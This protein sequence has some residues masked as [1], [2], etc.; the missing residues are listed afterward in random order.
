MKT[1]IYRRVDD[2][3][4][5]LRWFHQ[6]KGKN[7]TCLWFFGETEEEVREAFARFVENERTNPRHRQEID[8]AAAQ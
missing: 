5:A 1:E 7:T 3:K 8:D 4:Y 6:Q 2:G